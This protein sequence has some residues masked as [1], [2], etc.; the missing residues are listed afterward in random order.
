[1][2]NGNVT[3]EKL[4]TYDIVAAPSFDNA[5]METLDD[6][7]KKQW[8]KEYTEA[9]DEY[10]IPKSGT[11]GSSGTSGVTG[12]LGSWR[13]NDYCPKCGSNNGDIFDYHVKCNDCNWWGKEYELRKPK[14]N[15]NPEI[16][17]YGEENWYD[18]D[19]PDYAKNIL[20]VSMKIAAQT[21]GLDLVAVKPMSSPR[22]KDLFVDF[23]Y[24]WKEEPKEP[25]GQIFSD[26][27]PYGEEDWNA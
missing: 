7:R 26:I 3:I 16:D 23:K 9:M 11:S 18:D 14:V 13:I 24:S 17:P 22:M 10:Y 2:S 21:I 8:M 20:P 27:D 12:R 4:F 15:P 1:M 25:K 6:R 5:K 19:V